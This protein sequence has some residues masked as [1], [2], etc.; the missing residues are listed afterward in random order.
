MIYLK[1]LYYGN[2]EKPVMK[3]F[4]RMILVPEEVYNAFN[5]ENKNNS[6]IPPI[7]EDLEIRRGHESMLTN[8]KKEFGGDYAKHI[9]YQQNFKRIKKLISDKIERPLRITFDDPSKAKTSFSPQRHKNLK[10]KVQSEDSGAENQNMNASSPDTVYTSSF[11]NEKSSLPS[12]DDILKYIAENAQIFGVD[13]EGRIKN[14]TT[15]EPLK[16][17]KIQQIVQHALS[18]KDLPV[19]TPS[20]LQPSKVPTGYAVFI[21]SARN[22]PFLSRALNLFD[23]DSPE[24]KVYKTR[25]QSGKGFINNNNRKQKI[26]KLAFHFKP[27]LW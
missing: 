11:E 6:I 27:K 20:S 2:I 12:F 13:A 4:T 22:D 8:N 17:S 25:K 23:Y 5:R 15:G 10:N 21:N 9:H 19:S 3:H 18:M 26:R 14:Q 1:I 16:T 7:G 24:K